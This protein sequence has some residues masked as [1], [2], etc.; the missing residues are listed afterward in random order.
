MELPVKRTAKRAGAEEVP[1]ETPC[2]YPTDPVPVL[3]LLLYP[4]L[5][6]TPSDCA[7]RCCMSRENLGCPV[8][9]AK[10]P[11]LDSETPYGTHCGDPLRDFFSSREKSMCR[12]VTQPEE[13]AEM[14]VHAGGRRAGKLEMI[15]AWERELNNA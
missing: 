10:H 2:P 12:N 5:L 3:A 1:R 8:N 15:R 6:P 11:P 4:N 7:G 13:G 9:K 14:R